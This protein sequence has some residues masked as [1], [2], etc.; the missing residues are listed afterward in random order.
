MIAVGPKIHKLN[1]RHILILKF[2]SLYW[3]T[4][5]TEFVILH[6]SINNAATKWLE[7]PYLV[8][9]FPSKSILRAQSDEGMYSEAM[10]SGTSVPN[11]FYLGEHTRQRLRAALRATS[12]LWPL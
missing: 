1:N 11:R 8:A 12:G 9:F 2:K 10:S 3:P 7:N 5:S 4:L 6:C